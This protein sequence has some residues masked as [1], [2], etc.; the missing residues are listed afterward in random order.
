MKYTDEQYLAFD[1]FDGDRDVDVRNQ[2]T[3]MVTTKKDHNCTSPDCGERVTHVIPK[4]SRCRFESAVVD[5]EWCR[6]YVC[7]DCMDR[8]LGEFHPELNPQP[9]GR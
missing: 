5:G 3:K 9:E 6:Y 1:P 7:T 2:T 8:F 4:G